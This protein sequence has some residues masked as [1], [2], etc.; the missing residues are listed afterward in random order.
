MTANTFKVLSTIM[1]EPNSAGAD[2]A[3]STGLKTGTLY[4]ILMRL[5]EAGWLRS[6]WE[7]GDPVEM[8]RPRRRLYGVTAV[9]ASQAS[10]YLRE[11]QE[12]FG[13]LAW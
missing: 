6:E 9:G 3:R 2:I 7:A 1:S 10:T 13:R 4:P 8:K 11:H 12:V 5:E